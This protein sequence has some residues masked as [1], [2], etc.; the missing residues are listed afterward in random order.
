MKKFGRKI[1]SSLLAC[2]VVF[3]CLASVATV[4]ASASESS[5]ADDVDYYG[6]NICDNMENYLTNWYVDFFGSRAQVSPNA[7]TV[8]FVD[9][10][11]L[12]YGILDH[13]C[14][15]L[16]DQLDINLYWGNIYENT[17]ILFLLDC[18]NGVYCDMEYWQ[19]TGVVRYYDFSTDAAVIGFCDF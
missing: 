16:S 15:V 4:T 17:G 18:G 6:E 14:Q 8:V 19:Y 10:Q 5:Y 3:T 11:L 13:L 9:S 12:D 2:L 1:L 7:E